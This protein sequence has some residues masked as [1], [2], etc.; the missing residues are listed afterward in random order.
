M[1]QYP[2]AGSSVSCRLNL[3]GYPLR[4]S[5]ITT[6]DHKKAHNPRTKKKLAFEVAKR[7][8]RYVEELKVCRARAKALGAPSTNASWQPEIYYELEVASDLH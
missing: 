5:Q 6:A 1:F 2:N 7:I 8:K 4:S 3:S